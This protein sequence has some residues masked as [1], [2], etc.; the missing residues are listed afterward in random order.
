[1]S[2]ADLARLEAT[3]VDGTEPQSGTH[4]RM[5]MPATNEIEREPI[6]EVE[7]DAR[8]ARISTHL[9]AVRWKPLN[10]LSELAEAAFA[11]SSA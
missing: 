7:L 2:E 1:M 11:S 4:L 5:A 9:P 3:I 6:K 10:P 8:G